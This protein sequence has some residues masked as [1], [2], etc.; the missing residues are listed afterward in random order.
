MSA[1]P[2]VQA[3]FEEATELIADFGA[4][5]LRLD[6]GELHAAVIDAPERA[7]AGG[8]VADLGQAESVDT[9]I[10]QVLVALRR[11]LVDAGKPWRVVGVPAAVGDRWRLAGLAGE[12]D[13]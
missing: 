6:V 3:F 5:L 12:I 7:P 11:G 2:M 13:G 1:D 8:V 4:G 9:A 10:A